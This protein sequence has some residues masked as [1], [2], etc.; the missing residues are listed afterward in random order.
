MAK[1]LNG[2]VSDY[3]RKFWLGF[4]I[5]TIVG[6]IYF[7]YLFYSEEGYLPTVAKNY[8][9]LLASIITANIIAVFIY[10]TDVF[11]NRR[12]PW[13]EH[14]SARLMIGLLKN[15]LISIGAIFLSGS[16]LAVIEFDGFDFDF[17]WVLYSDTSIKLIIITLIAIVVYSL[18]Y[19]AL[20]SYNQYAV[21]HINAVKNQRKQLKL[22]FDAL[23]SQLSPHYLFNSLNTISSLVFRDPYLAEDFIRRLAATYQ[24]ILDNNQRQYVTLQEEIDFVK[25]YNYL[26]KVRFENSLH[27][28][29]NLPPNIMGTKMPP[30]TLQMLVENAIKHNVITRDQPMNIYISA[31]DNTDIKVTNTKTRVPAHI[32][33]F[34]VGLD[35]IKKR[36]RYFTH[37]DIRIE[38]GSKFTVKLPVIK[39]ELSKTG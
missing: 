2:L 26:L 25:S 16:I 32:N 3:M 37:K 5:S 17:L 36:Y 23:K 21:V 28:D 27:L 20:F 31:I 19:F 6:F 22:Q 1:I 14:L 30:L 9:Y 39:D 13:Q 24:Y 8:P 34:H 33:S 18:I 29:I 12:L 35:N 10:K 15:L 11:L 38:D 4:V 7:L